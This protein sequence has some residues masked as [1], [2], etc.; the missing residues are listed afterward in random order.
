MA[1]LHTYHVFLLAPAY[2]YSLHGPL[3]ILSL[4]PCHDSSLASMDDLA[5]ELPLNHRKR[6]ARQDD[7]E[8]DKVKSARQKRDSDVAVRP[9]KAPRLSWLSPNTGSALWNTPA[10]PQVSTPVTSPSALAAAFPL[11]CSQGVRESIL[12][13]QASSPSS[14]TTLALSGSVNDRIESEG[15]EPVLCQSPQLPL[16]VPDV[17]PSIAAATLDLAAFHIPPMIPLINRQTLKDLDFNEIMYNTPLR[18]DILFDS[19]LQ[20]RPAGYRR[21]KEFVERYW[22]AVSREIESGCTCVSFHIS[23][24]KNIPTVCVCSHVPSPTDAPLGFPVS[25]SLITIR[26]PPR[27]RP[28]LNEFLE[29]L[30][31]VIQ[32]LSMLSGPYVNP[33][34]LHV[35]IQ[36]HAQQAKHIRSLF[37]PDLIEQELKHGVFDPSGLFEVIGAT[38][39]AHCAPMRDLAVDSMVEAAKACA[40]GC[41]ATTRDAVK[42]I[43][44]CLEILE[45]MKLDIA[46][47]QMQTLR[48]FLVYSSGSFERKMLRSRRSIDP[49]LPVTKE[50]L[51]SA[52]NTFSSHTEPIK[53][54]LRPQGLDYDSLGKK[55]QLYVSVVRGIVDTVFSPPSSSSTAAP[56]TNLRPSP[57]EHPFPSLPETLYLDQARIQNHTSEIT[58]TV[59]LWMFLLLYRQLASC[60]SQGKYQKER[61]DEYG[62]I[63]KRE[64]RAI[65]PRSLGSCFLKDTDTSPDNSASAGSDQS[66]VADKLRSAVDDVVLQVARRATSVQRNRDPTEMVSPHNGT[67]DV[68]DERTVSVARKWVFTNMKS[69]SSLRNLLHGRLKKLVFEKVLADVYPAHG[70]AALEK[71]MGQEIEGCGEVFGPSRDYQG[72]SSLPR[73]P[74]PPSEMKRPPQVQS[75][76]NGLEVL[77]EEVQSL[78]DKI[79]LLVVVHF[80]A[81]LPLYE[82]DEFLE[83]AL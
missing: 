20:F 48:P 35:P 17:A 25:P 72:V 40:P 76:G 18:H 83:A 5:H 50:W 24:R 15:E 61:M 60:S 31:H 65:G 6:K 28:L 62:A 66:Q 21:K 19:G 56:S 37:D 63:L 52:H 22:D 33:D 55:H 29:V 4:F 64:I 78:V 14:P 69:D 43:R 42:V 8:D 47:H 1:C 80:N 41:N 77:S 27:I 68:P 51:R 39:K 74:L 13:G 26:T 57:L 59:A 79:S 44:T 71:M 3:H 75:W 7:H 58:D 54:P 12:H 73:S 67:D 70:E 45:L 32:P 10:S 81:Y 53:H 23:S 2:L 49:S 38:L 16:D 36:E 30:L 46:N 82:K 9:A 11:K 34:C